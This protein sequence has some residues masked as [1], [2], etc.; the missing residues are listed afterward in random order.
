MGESRPELS[1]DPVHALEPGSSAMIADG[2]PH[3]ERR[4]LILWFCAARPVAGLQ[5]DRVWLRGGY[6][7]EL[8]L[9][10]VGTLE[11]HCHRRD[12]QTPRI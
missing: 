3:K 4:V 1:G 2:F 5:L 6:V 9:A 7:A 8:E 11:V 12:R 10:T